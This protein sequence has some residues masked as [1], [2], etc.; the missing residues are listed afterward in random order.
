M[1][2]R[3]T[4]IQLGGNFA[5]RVAQEVSPDL[6]DSER[7]RRIDVIR[8]EIERDRELVREAGGLFVIGTERHESRRIDN[9]LRGRSGR[10]GDPGVSI[11]FLSLEDDLMRVFGSEKME[12]LLAH[13]SIGLREGEALTHPWISKALEKA[14]ARVEAMNFEVRKNLLKFDNVMNDQRKVIYE[15]RREIM[16]ARQVEDIVTEMRHGVIQD[17]VNRCVPQRSYA[18][19]WDINTLKSEILRVLTLDLPIDEWAREEG[20]ADQEIMERIIEAADRRMAEKAVNAGVDFFRR[21]EK[22]MVLQQ[23]DQHWKEHLLNLDHLRQGIN[24]RAFGQRD[25]LN[26]YK[27]EA[28]SM[29]AMMLDH[30]RESITQTLS[31]VEFNMDGPPMPPPPARQKMQ[32]TRQDPAMAGICGVAVPLRPQQRAAQDFDLNDPSTWGRIQRN[33]PCP[34]GSGKKFKQC[35]GSVMA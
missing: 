5:M 22:A 1:A 35:H 11:F 23:L 17:M 29:F 4:D 3:G 14:Q 19:Q 32:E 28:F 6:P 27:T 24:L 31:L 26:E 20:I 15:Q 7:E 2:G 25:P 10:Q 16:D 34:C 30:L 9:Q 33:A 12:V 18:D 21:M 13:K 8:A